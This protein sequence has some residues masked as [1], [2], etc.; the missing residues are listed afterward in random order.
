MNKQGLATHETLELHELLSFK[1]VCLTKTKT[2]QNLVQDEALKNI[3]Q[4]DVQNSVADIQ[5]LQ[6]LLANAV[7]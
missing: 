5:Q 2:M 1:T 4:K 6:S 3:M 7:Q